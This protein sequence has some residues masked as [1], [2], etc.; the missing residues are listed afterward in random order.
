M[1]KQE[2]FNILSSFV[3]SVVSELNAS[4]LQIEKKSQANGSKNS[5]SSAFRNAAANIK[6]IW[7]GQLVLRNGNTVTK[8]DL[9]DFF[10]KAHAAGSPEPLRSI[11]G[12]GESLSS[13]IYQNAVRDLSKYT[14]DR[15][16]SIWEQFQNSV[17]AQTALEIKDNVDVPYAGKDNESFL[18]YLKTAKGEFSFPEA[19]DYG[20]FIKFVSSRLNEF[21]DKD[22][23]FK[24]ISGCVLVNCS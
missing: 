8:E 9:V 15:G 4:A 23:T 14:D 19:L 18:E 2:I 17:E 11:P 16:V 13:R 20:S 6:E 7:G 12:V 1:R 21:V 10:K 22:V 3:S 5:A 24:M